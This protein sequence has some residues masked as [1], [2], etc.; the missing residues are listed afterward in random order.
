LPIIP[1]IAKAEAVRGAL[2]VLV[3]SPL[4]AGSAAAQQSGE[5]LDSALHAARAEQAAAEAEVA[6]LDGIA[7]KARGEAE[8]LR[9][10]Q[11]A[12]AEAIEAAEARITAADTQLRLASA[13]VAAHRQRLAEEQRPVS[14][15][16]AGLAIMGRRPPLLALAGS[17]SA[18]EFVKVRTL[19]DSTLPV[20]RRRTAGIA[21]ELAEGKRLEQAALAARSEVVRSRQELVSRRQQFASLE[22]RAQKQE[23]AAG[24]RALGVGDVAI[25][26]G[27]DIEAIRREQS[28]S[29]SARALAAQLALE[30]P[31]PPRPFAP[32]GAIERPPFAY[33]L[34]ATSP[35]T[36]GLDSVDESGVRSRGITLATPRGAPVVAPA[37]GV[38]RF[39]G[40]FRDY[41]GVLI[42]DHGRGWMS[43]I[44]NISSPLKTGDKVADGDAAGRALGPIEVELSHGGNW[45]SPALIA[46]SSGSL[47][48]NAKGR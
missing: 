39:S 16:L 13:Y 43:L 32:E 38:V 19:I 11:A 44:V 31:A 6:R 15:L 36:D 29:R 30:A 35:V 5:P 47:S 7:Q 9:A 37:G 42:I 40:P 10:E 46:G 2:L 24:G 23:L 45:L 21:A 17:G 26:A 28:G 33:R 34:P 3:A 14:S 22:Q 18:D 4:L 20:I 25:A 1:I 48:N 12:A 27:E 41:D 8:R